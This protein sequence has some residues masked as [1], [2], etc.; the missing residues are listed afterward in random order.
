MNFISG[1][2]RDRHIYI[3]TLVEETLYNLENNQSVSS[4]MDRTTRL[5]IVAL[6]ANI[7]V[8]DIKHSVASIPQSKQASDSLP[9]LAILRSEQ[10]Q[11]GNGFGAMNEPQVSVIRATTEPLL[12]SSHLDEMQELLKTRENSADINE[13]ISEV[14][15]GAYVTGITTEVKFQYKNNLNSRRSETHRLLHGRPTV[16]LLANRDGKFSRKPSDTSVLVHEAIHVRQQERNPLPSIPATYKEA[17]EAELAIE[18][19]A[20]HHAGWYE[21]GLFESKDERYAGNNEVYANA[22]IESERRRHVKPN[23]PYKPDQEFINWLIEIGVIGNS[24]TSLTTL[25]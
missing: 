13:G 18:L 1:E 3:D 25:E 22:Y 20:Y 12:F 21:R 23:E 14:S 6:L 16:V 5:G 2:S 10:I 7:V 11:L 24:W 8:P 9:I 19:E 15:L 4:Q 17:L